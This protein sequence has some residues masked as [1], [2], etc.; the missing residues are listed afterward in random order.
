MLQMSN[1][2]Y[3]NIQEDFRL[4]FRRI[5]CYVCKEPNSADEQTQ[6]DD[7]QTYCVYCPYL[8]TCT[9]YTF[10][11]SARRALSNGII[12]DPVALKKIFPLSTHAT[13]LTPVT[14][15][16]RPDHTEMEGQARSKYLH[17]A[18]F[19][20]IPIADDFQSSMRLANLGCTLIE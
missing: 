16:W 5:W 11:E 17:D 7:K 6:L 15:A 1:A 13:R 9:C 10:S 12:L 20:E 8:W 19:L 4:N 3:W 14:G 18:F 2:Q